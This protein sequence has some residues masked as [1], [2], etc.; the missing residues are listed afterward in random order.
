[1]DICIPR[2]FNT[3]GPRQRDVGY[4]GVISIFTRRVLSNVPPIIYG[5]G[6]QTRDF[7]YIDDAVGALDLLLGYDKPITEPLNSS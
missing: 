3:F 6:L 5:N 7:M 1:M 4:G 2:L